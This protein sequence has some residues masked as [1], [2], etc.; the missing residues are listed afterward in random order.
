MLWQVDP[1]EAAKHHPDCTYPASCQCVFLLPKQKYEEMTQ[2][3]DEAIVRC[4]RS[5]HLQPAS[6]ET[7]E[8]NLDQ[9]RAEIAA[10]IAAHKP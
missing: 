9:L 6:W 10:I 3:V 7:V 4:G 2:L 1:E 5:I 8:N